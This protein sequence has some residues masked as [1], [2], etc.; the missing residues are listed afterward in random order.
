[1]NIW[2]DDLRDP[3]LHLPNDINKNII[4][5]KSAFEAKNFLF[6]D[7]TQKIETLYFDNELGDPDIKG[8]DLICFLWL[9]IDDFTSLKQVYLHSSDNIVVFKILKLY[10]NNFESKGIKMDKFYLV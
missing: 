1:M 4:W 6:S 7:N 5:L 9:H 3:T 10:K 2:I 8:E